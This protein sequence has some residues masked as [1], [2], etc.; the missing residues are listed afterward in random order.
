[1]ATTC[2]LESIKLHG[3]DWIVSCFFGLVSYLTEEA[4]VSL[5][6]SCDINVDATGVSLL[7]DFKITKMEFGAEILFIKPQNKCHENSSNRSPDFQ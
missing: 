7:S 6:K 1:L 5:T 2:P 4:F 3:F